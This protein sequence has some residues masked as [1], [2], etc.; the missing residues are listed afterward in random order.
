M[1]RRTLLAAPLAAA[2]GAMVVPP[3][4]FA[5]TGPRIRG[6]DISFTLQEESAG[7]AYRDGGVVRPIE[8]ILASRGA[9]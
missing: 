6:A 4:A 2:F 1:R 5:A 3:V 7:K 9:N 8:Q